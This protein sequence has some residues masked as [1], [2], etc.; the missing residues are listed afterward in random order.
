MHG[1]QPLVYLDSANTS[2]KPRQVHRRDER[3]LRAAQR[4]RPPGHARA[5]PRRRP[6]A[7]RA[8]AT[9]SP[10]FIDAPAPRRGRLHQEHLRGAQPGRVHAGLGRRALPVGPG[11]EIVI[12]EMEHHSNIVPWQLLAQRTGATLR[13]FGITDEGRLDLSR[14]RRAD[15]RADQGRLAA[16]RCPTCSARVNPVA[17]DRRRGPRGRRAG[18][19]STRSQAVP[20]MPVDVPALGADFLAFTGHK[21]LRPD[22]HRR[23][24]GPPRAAGRRCRRSSAAAR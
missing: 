1:G 6:R 11:D 10:R 5:R 7:T 12:T 13:W 9:R 16:C 21:M 15:H 14:H 22:R 8:P 3:V 4:Q 17:R 2:Q 19:W 24:V 18:A 23:A 20:H